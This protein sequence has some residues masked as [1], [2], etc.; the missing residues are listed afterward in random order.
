V[1]KIDKKKPETIIVSPVASSWYNIDFDVDFDDS[2][3][4]SGL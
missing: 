3:D 1:I 4:G 2:D